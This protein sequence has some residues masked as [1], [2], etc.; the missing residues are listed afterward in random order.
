ML[1]VKVLD[2]EI[3]RVCLFCGFIVYYLIVEVVSSYSCD[4][5]ECSSVDDMISCVDVTAPRFKYR[6]TATMLYMD[7]V[8][9]VNLKDIF[10]KLPNLRFLT[11]MNM[12]YFKCNLLLDLSRD[13]YLKTN[14]CQS[15]STA[16]DSVRQQYL[17][18]LFRGTEINDRIN[19]ISSHTQRNYQVDI[20]SIKKFQ[21]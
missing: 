19:K 8:Q 17:T 20:K 13:T 7:I 5:S 6:A 15:Y 12:K 21:I 2:M 16:T 4:Y 10:R 18:A 14:M 3:L 11:L 1:S 9:V